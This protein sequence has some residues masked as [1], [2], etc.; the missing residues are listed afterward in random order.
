MAGIASD[1]PAGL[2]VA[3]VG[4]IGNDINVTPAVTDFMDAFRSGFI[5]FDDINRRA[6]SQALIP[7]DIAK[8]KAETAQDTL[9]AETIRPLQRELGAKSIA[10]ELSLSDLAAA[11]KKKNLELQQ[12][13]QELAEAMVPVAQKQVASAVAKTTGTP[14]EQTA[15]INDEQKR[16]TLE[17]YGQL[18]REVPDTV[19]IK[20]DADIQP[21]SF[22]DWIQN[23][24]GFKQHLSSV[25][26]P[27]AV[28][29][30]FIERLKKSPEVQ[31]EYADYKKE[32]AN[33]T[34]TIGPDDPRYFEALNN[35][36]M[37]KEQQLAVQ[38]ATVE[39]LPGQLVAQT[40][41]QAERPQQ[42]RQE[43]Q[44]YFADYDNGQEIKDLRKVQAAFNK[45]QQ[46][47][48]PTSTPPQ[49]MST[50]FS[51]MKILDP[52]STVREGEYAT[53]QN[54]RGIPETVSNLYNQVLQG[55]KLTPAQRQQFLQ[56][57]E[58]NLVGQAQSALP[59][60]KQFRQKEV[61]LDLPSGSIVPVEDTELLSKFS[62]AAPSA[63]IGQP[64]PVRKNKN[65]VIYEQQPDGRYKRIN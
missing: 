17:R 3:Q 12:G 48:S 57:A 58:G 23:D 18:F 56:A 54:A 6:Q 43:A 21:A 39:A 4:T 29:P 36:A 20:N 41:I 33:R 37:V 24:P 47:I 35:K 31:K 30:A 53:A 50:I 16:T 61:D 64:A 59:R 40:K 34:M 60:I 45:I 10:D 32:A 19:E 49:D 26:D 15:T 1:R 27:Q 13:Q 9:D 55:V 44:K 51:F 11:V 5:S 25:S 28:L 63:G 52:G 22:E 2:Q 14:Q 8:R 65:G 42:Q 62:K 38:K 7:G 46:S